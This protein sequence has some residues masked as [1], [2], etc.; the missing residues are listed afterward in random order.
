[1]RG[2]PYKQNEIKKWKMSLELWVKRPV[3]GESVAIDAETN[4]LYILKFY[5]PADKMYLKLGKMILETEGAMDIIVDKTQLY[6]QR[7]SISVEGPQF[8][9]GDFVIRVGNM[10]HQSSTK[11]VI[12]E[13]EYLPAQLPNQ[14]DLIKEF[15][16][17]FAPFDT[18]FIPPVDYSSMQLPQLYTPSHTAFQ[19]YQL[20]KQIL[21]II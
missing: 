12:V 1:L 11:G 13:V 19:Y 15:I 16:E 3:E 8:N 21:H 4:E 7:Q 9:F 18:S 6:Q 5:D 14:V 10:I 2:S 17:N 20:I